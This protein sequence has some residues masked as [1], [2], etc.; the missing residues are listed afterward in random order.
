[1]PCIKLPR[2]HSPILQI[3]NKDILVLTKLVS[4][5]RFQCQPVERLDSDSEGLLL[6][7]NNGYL[8][9]R[10]SDRQLA[11]PRTYWVQG[12]RLPD[13]DVFHWLRKGVRQGAIAR[14]EG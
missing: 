5:E 1:M 2:L 10:L 6:L 9:H 7:T 13:E 12:S 8:Q 3:L 4:T 11:H 14:C